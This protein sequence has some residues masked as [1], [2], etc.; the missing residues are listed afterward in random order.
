MEPKQKQKTK[1]SILVLMDV[2]LKPR[3]S[4]SFSAEIF[5]SILVLMDV[6]LKP[7]SGKI[8]TLR[9]CLFQSLFWWMLVLNCLQIC[10]D[11]QW[12][13]QFQSLFWWM[14][15][16]NNIVPICIGVESTVSILVL[17]DVGLK[18]NFFFKHIV[19]P[20]VSILV[21]MDVGLKQSSFQ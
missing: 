16:L 18:L 4:Q 7:S 3:A 17:M 21:L 12:F 2:G 9:R 5:V 1:V 8:R 13:K 14:L 11:L 6:G 20:S 15:V 19:I 10:T